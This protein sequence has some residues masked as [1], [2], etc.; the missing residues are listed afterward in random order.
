MSKAV[1][2]ID[3]RQQIWFNKFEAAE[4]M[5][6]LGFRSCTHNSVMHAHRTRKLHEGRQ[7]GK[8]MHWHRDWLDEWASRGH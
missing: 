6:Q 1:A 4:Y 8:A 3:M 5:R 7:D 2:T